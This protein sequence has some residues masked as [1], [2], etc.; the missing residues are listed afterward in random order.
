MP[1][2][3]HSYSDSELLSL[4]SKG[5]EMAF[6]ELYNRYWDKL[7]FI[8]GIKFRDLAVAE[9]MVQDIFLDIW[10]RRTALN[11]IGEPEAYLAVSM[12]YKVINAQAKLKR[13]ADY[14]KHALENKRPEDNSTEELLSFNE[15]KGKLSQFVSKLPEKCR[16]T[17][18]LSRED[19]L[20]QREI[21]IHLDIT[22]KAVEANLSR[23]RK[24]LR[25]AFKHIL[26]GILYILA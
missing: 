6:T 11:I 19:G 7:F 20:S 21:A 15:L 25:M 16:V 2:P 8:A 24:S 9:E 5:D 26:S 1:E 14:Q 22:E 12:K 13:A 17:Y 18:Q 10:N 3:L 4:I 23:A